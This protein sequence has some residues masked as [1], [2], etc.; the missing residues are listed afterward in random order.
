MIIIKLKGGLGNQLF[1]YAL[2]RALSS[3]SGMAL[4]LDVSGFKQDVLRSYRLQHLC[5]EAELADEREIEALNPPKSCYVAWLSRRCKWAFQSFYHRSYVKERGFPFDPEI[6]EI[7]QPVYLNGYWQSEKYFGSLRSTLLEELRPTAPFSPENAAL[8]AEMRACES[9]SLHI[10]RGDYAANPEALKVHGVVPLDYYRAAA[11]KMAEG[12]K[13]PRFFIFS[14]DMEWVRENLDVGHPLRFV[15]ADRRNADYEDLHLM[16]QC[17]H[18]IIANSSFSWWG[19]WLNRNPDKIVV[20]PKGWFAAPIDTR[21][22]I[23]EAWL[24]L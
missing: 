13:R 1:Q 19:A 24:Q 22:L 14:D 18:Q 6:L 9:V 3:K 23:P 17:R 20:A 5:V 16:S 2:G 11:A 10:R 12:L 8:A 7:R 21:D 15:G 4:K